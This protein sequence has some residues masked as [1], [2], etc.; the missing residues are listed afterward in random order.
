MTGGDEVKADPALVERVRARLETDGTVVG[1]TDRTKR[2]EVLH[3][4]AQLAVEELT[5][6]GHPLTW[7]TA[8]TMPRATLEVDD[9][10]DVLIGR[11]AVILG[12][13]DLGHR[14]ASFDAV[15]CAAQ[16]LRGQ[17][18]DE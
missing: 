18:S 16:R 6:S 12:A 15:L 9:P 11:L 17:S 10:R 7:T 8:R 4:A 2:P 13:A 14:G 5:V 3:R 1:G